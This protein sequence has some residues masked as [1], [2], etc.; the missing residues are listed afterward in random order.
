MVFMWRLND[1]PLGQRATR[2]TER[3]ANDGKPPCHVI[4]SSWYIQVVGYPSHHDAWTVLHTSILCLTSLDTYGKAWDCHA[5]IE[6]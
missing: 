1:A 6:Y 4:I 3:A 5:E 2:A